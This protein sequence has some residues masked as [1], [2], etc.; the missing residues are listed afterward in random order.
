MNILLLTTH[1]NCG[2]ITRY[3]INLTKILGK[4]HRVW[5]A[6]S[7][8]EW[9]KNLASYC[10]ELIFIPI[11][12]KSIISIKVFISF[13][14]LIPFII[15]NKVDI[16]CANTRVTQFLAYLLYRA[17]GVKYVSVYHGF[18]RPHLIRKLFKF[19]G[20][21]TIAVSKAVK[22]HLVGDLGIPQDKIRVIYHGIDL[23][24]LKKSESKKDTMGFK[25]EDVV[26]GV[27]GRIS[28]EKGHFLVIEAF[29]RLKEKYPHLYLLISGEG[30]LKERLKMLIKKEKLEDRVKLITSRGEDFLSMVDILIVASSKE[31]FG[32]VILE[33]FAMEVCVIGFAVGGIKEIIKNRETGLL[34]YSYTPQALASTIEELVKNRDLRVHLAVNG[35]KSLADFTL[36]KMGQNTE[37]ILREALSL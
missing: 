25:N 12:T 4:H 21:R 28:P 37:S 22:N 9:E 13:F 32:Y 14:K 8:G 11:R 16:V 36:E 10:Q 6:S 23:K 29:K 35:K 26:C 20:V 34:F 33:A 27:L 31:G 18:Y 5:V 7:G 17:L 3:L 19:E 24:E 15:R 30:R 2:G 1:L